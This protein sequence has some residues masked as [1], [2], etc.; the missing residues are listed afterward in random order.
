[1]EQRARLYKSLATAICKPLTDAKSHL[2]QINRINDATFMEVAQAKHY[3]LFLDT[4]VPALCKLLDV[5][6]KPKLTD[7]VV[8]E[9]RSRT[10]EIFVRLP[11][12]D[13]KKKHL[14]AVMQT[15]KH[16]LDCDSE[17]NVLLAL[18]VIRTLFSSFSDELTSSA[19]FVFK[20]IEHVF[21]SM[22]QIVDARFKNP[23]GSSF[24]KGQESLKILTELTRMILVLLK[25]FPSKQS[26]ALESIALMMISL[27][28]HYKQVIEPKHGAVMNDFATSQIT[29]L[30]SLFSL[31]SSLR[32]RTMS[33]YQGAIVS[34]LG[35]L[36]QHCPA[37]NVVTRKRLL[38][39]TR[40]FMSTS[41]AQG[42]GIIVD[43]LLDEKVLVGHLYSQK[44]M[45]R[46]NLQAAAYITMAEVVKQQRIEL[47]LQQITKVLRVFAKNVHNCN[48]TVS[49]Q[50][51]SLRALLNLV[52]KINQHITGRADSH[53][54]SAT[55]VNSKSEQCR[56]LLMMILRTV[57]NKIEVIKES[58]PRLRRAYAS[59]SHFKPSDDTEWFLRQHESLDSPKDAPSDTALGTSNVK[60]NIHKSQVVTPPTDSQ[61]DDGTSGFVQRVPDTTG[62]VSIDALLGA[63]PMPNE[64]Q[65]TRSRANSFSLNDLVSHEQLREPQEDSESVKWYYRCLFSGKSF[66]GI[67]CMDENDRFSRPDQVMHKLL[68]DLRYFLR[69]MVDGL[70]TVV[71]CLA[72]LAP[73]GAR[74]PPPTSLLLRFHKAAMAC[75]DLFNIANTQD[76]YSVKAAQKDKSELMKAHASV[77]IRTSRSCLQD[78]VTL[79]IASLVRACEA[80]PSYK[81]FFDR[82]LQDPKSAIILIDVGM[83]FL[84]KE[85]AKIADSP[86]L[87]LLRI[88][89]S[90]FHDLTVCGGKLKKLPGPARGT[91]H[92]LGLNFEQLI[93]KF[94][95]P[96][97]T[98]L[99]NISLRSHNAP[100][101]LQL[102]TALIRSVSE[103]K[104][105]LDK[106]EKHISSVVRCFMHLYD[107]TSSDRVKERL[108]TL[109]I[110]CL[111]MPTK[112]IYV[113]D[114]PLYLR[115][116]VLSLNMP[117]FTKV[118]IRIIE[119]WVDLVSP[120]QL[121][122][123]LKAH[124]MLDLLGRHLFRLVKDR[125]PRHCSTVLRLL[126]KL[127]G[128]NRVF[129]EKQQRLMFDTSTMFASLLQ[130]EYAADGGRGS[131]ADD[132]VVVECNH[133]LK[134][135]ISYLHRHFRPCPANEAG[136][137]NPKSRFKY[138]TDETL[139][140]DNH[141]IDHRWFC[142]PTF[143]SD[144]KDSPPS[145]RQRAATSIDLNSKSDSWCILHK[146]FLLLYRQYQD[147]KQSGIEDDLDG[148]DGVRTEG[149]V[150]P[151][152][153]H[154]IQSAVS[155]TLEAI[156]KTSADEDLRPRIQGFARGI[157]RH[158][159]TWALTTDEANAKRRAMWLVDDVQALVCRP[160]LA[161]FM[162]KERSLA[163]V[164][165]DTIIDSLLVAA[166]L[167]NT[168][169]NWATSSAWKSVSFAH[170]RATPRP[171]RETLRQYFSKGPGD[172]R[173]ALELFTASPQQ[174]NVAGTALGTHW[175]LDA[176]ATQR[177]PVNAML[178]GFVDEAV[179]MCGKAS[180]SALKKSILLII[181]LCSVAGPH[182]VKQHH[183]KLLHALCFFL[184]QH[185]NTVPQDVQNA[186]DVSV[187]DLLVLNY[188]TAQHRNAGNPSS[189]QTDD[190]EQD[191]SHG[192]GSVQAIVQFICENLVSRSKSV[193]SASKRILLLVAKLQADTAFGII[194][195]HWSIFKD[196]VFPASLL[197]YP[198][199]KQCAILDALLFILS[200]NAVVLRDI[201]SNQIV[202]ILSEGL[203][204]TLAQTPKPFVSRLPSAAPSFDHTE[205]CC[206]RHVFDLKDEIEKVRHDNRAQ[207]Q[208]T[209]APL[210]F[211][212]ILRAELRISVLQ[213]SSLL[214]RT[215]WQILS[216]KETQQLRDYVVKIIRSSLESKVPELMRC[217]VGCFVDLL[218]HF[219]TDRASTTKRSFLLK[220]LDPIQQKLSSFRHL[221]LTLLLQLQFLLQAMKRGFNSQN[222]GD[223]LLKHL[224]KWTDPVAVV[225]AEVFRR[226]EE[227]LVA[228]RLLGLLHLLPESTPTPAASAE[229]KAATTPEAQA[230]IRARHTKINLHRRRQF[231]E[232]VI[233]TTAKLESVVSKFS[234][235]LRGIYSRFT[236]PFR[237]PIFQYLDANPKDAICFFCNEAQFSSVT[238]PERA[239]KDA[240]I[241]IV[242]ALITTPLQAPRI[243]AKLMTAEWIKLVCDHL[244]LPYPQIPQTS[245]NMGGFHHSPKWQH[246]RSVHCIGLRVVLSLAESEPGWLSKQAVLCRHLLLLWYSK[247]RQ[248]LVILNLGGPE[249]QEE[250]CLLAKCL[251]IFA[252]EKPTEVDVVFE[253]LRPL[254]H[255]GLVDYTFLRAFFL[256]DVAGSTFSTQSKRRLIRRYTMLA[257]QPKFDPL[258]QL[259]ALEM[260]VMPVLSSSFQTGQMSV[261]TS[262]MLKQLLVFPSTN[263]RDGVARR[264][265]AELLKLTC[266]VVRYF[267]RLLPDTVTKY[268]TSFLQGPDDV[269]KYWAFLS[270][271]TYIRVNV[272]APTKAILRVYDYLLHATT[273]E[274][275]AYVFEALKI[276]MPALKTRLGDELK[277]VIHKTYKVAYEEGRRGIEQLRHVWEFIIRYP[278][279]FYA[280]RKQ[281]YGLIKYT[282]DNYS[283]SEHRLTINIMHLEIVW[284]RRSLKEADELSQQLAVARPSAA[285]DNNIPRSK[286]KHS[287]SQQIVAD[288]LNRVIA[289]VVARHSRA[290]ATESVT[291]DNMRNNVSKRGRSSGM[292]GSG[293]DRGKRGS[294]TKRSAKRF[295]RKWKRAKPLKQSA[296]RFD[297]LRRF[298]KAKR[299][300][301]SDGVQDRPVLSKPVRRGKPMAQTHKNQMQCW[302][303]YL[304][305][306]RQINARMEQACGMLVRVQ[307]YISASKSSERDEAANLARR[308][309]SLAEKALAIAPGV[310]L[311]PSVFA[312]HLSELDQKYK[313]D[314]ERY[315]ESH[316]SAKQRLV[317]LNARTPQNNYS[318][319]REK[320]FA[321]HAAAKLF[322][323]EA[324]YVSQYVKA[325]EIAIETTRCF[326][327]N[328]TSTTVHNAVASILNSFKKAFEVGL[329]DPSASDGH[330]RNMLAALSSKSEDVQALSLQIVGDGRHPSAKKS[331]R[332]LFSKLL[333]LLS[334]IIGHRV[335]VGTSTAS[336][337]SFRN[338]QLSSAV[339]SVSATR[340]SSG[341]ALKL[342]QSQIDMLSKIRR[343][344]HEWTKSFLAIKIFFAAGP[345]CISCTPRFAPSLTALLRDL[346]HHQRV[347]KYGRAFLTQLRRRPN[348]GDASLATT[349]DGQCVET[350]GRILE[351]MRMIIP[352]KPSLKTSFVQ[353]M[354]KIVATAKPTFPLQFKSDFASHD[355]ALLSHALRTLGRSIPMFVG[356]TQ[357]HFDAT[358]SSPS[359]TAQEVGQFMVAAWP[360]VAH[361]R[362]ADPRLVS[363]YV[364]LN[365]RFVQNLRLQWAA[366]PVADTTNLA[367]KS[368]PQLLAGQ[369]ARIRRNGSVAESTSRQT[370]GAAGLS[371]VEQ[372]TMLSFTHDTLVIGLLVEDAGTRREVFNE[373]YRCDFTKLYE[374]F[375]SV[376]TGVCTQDHPRAQFIDRSFFNESLKPSLIGRKTTSQPFD[377]ESPVSF[378][379]VLKTVFEYDWAPVAR[380]NFLPIIVDVLLLELNRRLGCTTSFSPSDAVLDEVITLWVEASSNAVGERPWQ[381][382]FIRQQRG[383]LDQFGFDQNF[384]HQRYARLMLEAV[385]SSCYHRPILGTKVFLQVVPSMWAHLSIDE[386]KDLAPSIVSLLSKPWLQSSSIGKSSADKLS[387]DSSPAS[388]GSSPRPVLL[389]SLGTS[390]SRTVVTATL[391]LC[392]LLD[393][394]PFIPSALLNYLGDA[395]NCWFSVAPL[396]T[397]NVA[398]IAFCRRDIAQQA[399]SGSP[400]ARRKPNEPSLG[401]GCSAD[402]VVPFRSLD[403]VLSTL[404]ASDL[405]YGLHRHFSSVGEARYAMSLEAQTKHAHAREAYAKAIDRASKSVVGSNGRYAEVNLAD[406]T[407][408]H[409]LQVWQ[410]RWISCTKELGDWQVLKDY[411]SSSNDEMLDRECQA[412]LG[413][414][415]SPLL[416]DLSSTA[417]KPN[418]LLS[419]AAQRQMAASTAAINAIND[420]F[421]A[422]LTQMYAAIAH[423]SSSTITEDM[424]KFES[425]YHRCEQQLLSSWASLPPLASAPHAPL[426][427]NT[428][429]L[430]EAYESF[431]LV[432]HFAEFRPRGPHRLD[433]K[434]KSIL[435]PWRKRVPTDGDPML[436]WDNCLTWRLQLFDVL[437]HK[438]KPLARTEEDGSLLHDAPWTATTLARTARTK[439]FHVLA[440]RTLAKLTM[441][442]M[443]R[444]DGFNKVREQLLI[445]FSGR[446]YKAG[447]LYGLDAVNYMITSVMDNF[448]AD[449]QAE[450][451]RIK[452][453]FLRSQNHRNLAQQAFS[454]AAQASTTYSA[455]WLSWGTFLHQQLM[456]RTQ[457]T[458]TPTSAFSLAQQDAN[459][460]QARQIL[461]CL[462]QAVTFNTEKSH[463]SI[464]RVLSLLAAYPTPAV[465]KTFAAYKNKVPFWAWLPWTTQ[466]L[467]GLSKT[468]GP[469]LKPILARVAY[470]AP[471]AVF[472]E[473]Q[474]AQG[475]LAAEAA[476][477]DKA[478]AEAELEA[479]KAASARS[480]LDNSVVGSTQQ[481]SPPPSTSKL[482]R[483]VS[484]F[485]LHGQTSPSTRT[486]A[487]QE[488]KDPS[489][490]NGNG[491][492]TATPT[493]PIL[494]SSDDSMSRCNVF[495]SL[496]NGLGAQSFRSC[497]SIEDIEAEVQRAKENSGVPGGAQGSSPHGV[498]APQARP[499]SLAQLQADQA[500][501]YVR[502]LLSL[503][504]R[505]HTRLFGALHLLTRVRFVSSWF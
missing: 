358:I 19:S 293:R 266:L 200:L 170:G 439:G 226:G 302:D 376:P 8:G 336:T 230:A 24:I 305:H 504:K 43:N 487:R 295:Q 453:E 89:H 195:R 231:M 135:A 357:S 303:R 33:K 359:L 111:V 286:P 96:L 478:S 460:N 419:L 276:L 112:K 12:K 242:E 140:F 405:Q 56:V 14:S 21:R 344:E 248:K 398:N 224:K 426:L 467:A 411:A 6:T 234:H 261:I 361:L 97:L 254:L 292:S 28:S 161:T 238:G 58:I 203:R 222:I 172:V 80:D 494:R 441:K 412:K 415:S 71:Y 85:F 74:L 228:S 332:I 464:V 81:A 401:T 57:V 390:S 285:A 500:A 125:D 503:V 185:Q 61:T 91:P 171:K 88:H 389:D 316:E 163:S 50:K 370:R 278:D 324:T 87:S 9:L 290:D 126:G 49:I 116:V 330:H 5:I 384:S 199:T 365:L 155:R 206:H 239:L 364:A 160:A 73:G 382:S 465:A 229:L 452:G 176:G 60:A 173:T 148:A 387:H 113:R 99:L 274:A 237:Q 349:F 256:N 26:K 268:M 162:N 326:L 209:L 391:S 423:S 207:K 327:D 128:R 205:L 366:E 29:M 313:R 153:F 225:R 44:T 482:F 82:V 408:Q 187:T 167:F 374:V 193:R 294:K 337:N 309:T 273:A 300:R 227:V 216:E 466:L 183:L 211:P 275:K 317:V 7:K 454:R 356:S 38:W 272:K 139:M 117:Q 194:S 104:L 343:A 189:T 270:V 449:E 101:A 397:D 208:D 407:S 144:F 3:A 472:Y 10:L 421:R 40:V 346:V 501:N 380:F 319:K 369:S 122:Q 301:L 159:T 214:I 446:P 259:K 77:F 363:L 131:G 430:L 25:K 121:Y 220:L 39:L 166:Q 307:L 493:N 217:A 119:W 158:V 146:G 204:L 175:H 59:L 22:P 287:T 76:G 427:R 69:E 212:L 201:P 341:Q 215:S 100:R 347:L 252:R 246:A 445:H 296:A 315:Q 243:R 262:Q 1:M 147:R 288:V 255:A 178:I 223:K 129:L 202:R 462:L 463:R 505:R 267:G 451:F 477:A 232:D 151:E 499:R 105:L 130:V 134:Y 67:V 149:S 368:L 196:V 448:R 197:L 72:Q 41:V 102:L 429:L 190:C 279:V 435:L 108:L 410:R 52:K 428:Q 297:N 65:P 298:L 469:M 184:A 339:F 393:P 345:E 45:D 353:A 386:Q 334:S 253:L 247:R 475:I 333:M 264:L 310:G 210:H 289:D 79:E 55:D 181:T 461:D 335:E 132:T 457:Q 213:L 152:Q 95:F 53:A 425:L 138:P 169:P 383:F 436:V 271:C 299:I 114:L 375:Q 98:N 328:S 11:N 221:N 68:T 331:S 251:V 476:A 442:H 180:D 47:S 165:F 403:N 20:F 282:L 110:L 284:A 402:T 418:G 260:I 385:R 497:S 422:L 42:F 18:K 329:A 431:K 406:D 157:V 459:Q 258:L 32:D 4:I 34:S 145:P 192:G 471:Q 249:M 150:R 23:R 433:E 257:A 395:H 70:N 372:D 308:C 51:T 437:R 75:Y 479:A 93:E 417:G 488:Q 413:N 351:L 218:R 322:A 378:Y 291:M 186:F 450:L 470:N 137:L 188:D 179:Q 400:S 420:N 94:L 164:G 277:V 377:E 458:T 62:N 373:W 142:A 168:S 154:L 241:A 240:K 78:V 90:L 489:D 123:V 468:E 416:Q 321:K 30:S 2:T 414:W 484:T 388:A 490:F 396:I 434:K 424:K 35:H 381:R 156:I 66:A 480:D 379:T 485:D 198:P 483:V 84:V 362:R 474:H 491:G 233:S 432:R 340:Q 404:Q 244:L 124:P 281:L 306:R 492:E 219:G 17:R 86:H 314:R 177:Q 409:E 46:S 481:S 444:I 352:R 245:S 360:A 103:S 486:L 342:T 283:R 456:T 440:N 143:S 265:H 311:Q 304:D 127:G 92:Q 136:C 502:D 367:W 323:C 83:Q 250:A 31:P 350:I 371:E 37:D 473:I 54:K 447:R 354:G 174:Q 280:T 338:L 118:S 236:S 320:E 106:F 27:S 109:C 36:L 438:F 392:S 325:L 48:L 348:G 64:L 498:P 63:E 355:A 318:I 107:R 312:F 495:L 263:P 269:C 443:E 13:A 133:I 394:R 15:M 120:D 235:N 141:P 16:V 399:G 182:W 455:A 496:G 115:P 191:A